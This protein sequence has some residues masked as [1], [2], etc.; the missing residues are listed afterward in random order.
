MK[1]MRTEYYLCHFSDGSACWVWVWRG[2]DEKSTC[3]IDDG[4]I[5]HDEA[6]HL[7]PPI[8]PGNQEIRI[9][10]K[11]ARCLIRSWKE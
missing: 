5:E 9:T 11:L 7:N 2:R 4:R 6:G 1:R 8:E 10:R 3:Y